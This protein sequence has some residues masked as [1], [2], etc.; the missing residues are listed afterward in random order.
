MEATCEKVGA[1][2]R[3]GRQAARV[4]AML[5]GAEHDGWMIRTEPA[6]DGLAWIRKAV[7]LG[8]GD[9]QPV[10]DASRSTPPPRF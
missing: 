8:D 5:H 7:R 1:I 4:Y 10:V 6:V 2:R 3:R 9:A